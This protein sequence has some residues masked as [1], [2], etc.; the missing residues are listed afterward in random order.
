MS[1]ISLNFKNFKQV[2]RHFITRSKWDVNSFVVKLDYDKWVKVVY[3]K[4]PFYD[5]DN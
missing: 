1:I 2:K 4:G 3:R 5:K